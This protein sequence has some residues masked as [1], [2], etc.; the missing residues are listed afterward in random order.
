MMSRTKS[1]SSIKEKISYSSDYVRALHL[2]DREDEHGVYSQP[3]TEPMQSSSLSHQAV[4][5][6][7]EVFTIIRGTFQPCLFAKFLHCCGRLSLSLFPE[8]LT[9]SDSRVAL[10]SSLIPCCYDVSG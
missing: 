6:E 9:Y 8:N 1:I 5:A 2:A 3:C 10:Y 4:T 7:A